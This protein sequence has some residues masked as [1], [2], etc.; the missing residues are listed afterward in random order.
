ML[1]S[2]LSRRM[3]GISPHHLATALDR[4]T[5]GVV[6]NENSTLSFDE[7]EQ[8]VV[9]LARLGVIDMGHARQQLAGLRRKRCDSARRL[10]T[11]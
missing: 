5:P 1:V 10:F 6:R 2:E 8:A 3:H 4:Q 11:R 7:A 9:D